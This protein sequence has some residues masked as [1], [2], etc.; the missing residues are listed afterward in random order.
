MTRSAGAAGRATGTGFVLG[1]IVTV[2][3]VIMLLLMVSPVGA[4]D[5]PAEV[6]DRDQDAPPSSWEPTPTVPAPQPAPWDQKQVQDVVS[7]WN[8]DPASEPTPSP[9]DDFSESEPYL[10]RERAPA[11]AF[12]GI[13]MVMMCFMMPLY[14]AIFVFSI[15]CYCKVAE[16][17]GYPWAYGLLTLVPFFNF[18]VMYVAAFKPWPIHK[19]SMPPM[20]GGSAPGRHPQP[21]FPGQPAGQ[22]GPSAGSG[23]AGGPSN[24]PPTPPRQ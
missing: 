14:L 2:L 13:F 7:R 24:V 10:S 16:K 15:V 11:A 4:Q 9:W 8:Q 20:G 5:A 6:P 18:Y 22:G 12:S 17:M 19:S 3:A 21:P 23:G 1:R